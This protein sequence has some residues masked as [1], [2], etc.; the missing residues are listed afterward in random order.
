MGRA[1]IALF[2]TAFF[3]MFVSFTTGIVGCWRTSPSNITSSAI[4][5]LMACKSTVEVKHVKC[6]EQKAYDACS[7]VLKPVTNIKSQRLFRRR[8]LDKR[9]DLRNHTPFCLIGHHV[10]FFCF[11][12]L[13][14]GGSHTEV[15]QEF[16]PSYDI[17]RRWCQGLFRPQVSCTPSL[18][19]PIAN[20]ASTQISLVFKSGKMGYMTIRINHFQLH[21]CSVGRS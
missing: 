9:V 7:Q 10:S 6:P 2:I 15:Y 14:Y 4:L 8:W 5:M 21:K 16:E 20:S 13:T 17:F 12:L 18:H 3:F 1:M 11:I 19:C